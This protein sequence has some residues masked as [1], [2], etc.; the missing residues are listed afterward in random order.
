M[1]DGR[2]V[3][4]WSTAVWRSGATGWLD[5]RLTRAGIHRTGAVEQTR[6]QPWG[7]VQTAPTTA[8]P[9]W[10]KAGSDD[11]HYEAGLY[12]VL[13]QAAPRFVLHPIAVD[14]DRGWLLLRDAGPPVVPKGASIDTL[15]DVLT[16]ALPEYAAL[17]RALVPHVGE[18]LAVGT[19]DMR[20]AALPAVFD[21]MLRATRAFVD[22]HGAAADQALWERT[23]ALRPAVIDGCERL[24]RSV[25]P[26]SL[27]HN[28]LHT[29]NI[30]S[31]LPGGGAFRFYDWG[32]S[33][34]AH[35]FTSML[36]CLGVLVDYYGLAPDDPRLLAAR[37]AYLA[38]FTDL[39]PLSELIGELELAC[40]LARIARALTW[41]RV[42]A[43]QP[44][45]DGVPGE[46]A[47][48]PFRVLSSMST[49]SY[50]GMRGI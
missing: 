18:M 6:I 42:A 12:R 9:V 22:R 4:V 33:G 27:D 31:G 32:D 1:S 49:G 25:I 23:A 28:D 44:E 7:T 39:A 37:D 13:V 19:R 16:R 29:E 41:E 47:G 38:P 30:R 46:F 20:P 26:S 21:E 17:Q 2:G 10:F 15:L 5:E 24:A 34:V 45:P 11:T 43:A 35:P 36:V 8:G 50:L 40:W 3:A 48:D 14:T